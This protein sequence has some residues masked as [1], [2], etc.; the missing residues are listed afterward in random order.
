[1]TTVII[2]I[3]KELIVNPV[4]NHAYYRGS[5][6]E[7]NELEFT[8]NIRLSEGY[9]ATIQFVLEGGKRNIHGL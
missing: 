9:E 2:D 3:V 1:M 7:E 8:E 6:S 4:F 5:Y